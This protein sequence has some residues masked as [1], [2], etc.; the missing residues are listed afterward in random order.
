[1]PIISVYQGGSVSRQLSMPRIYVFPPLSAHHL[2]KFNQPVTTNKIRKAVFDMTPSEAP[3][4]VGIHAR[5]Y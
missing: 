2:H 3:E 5:F 1:M 4:P